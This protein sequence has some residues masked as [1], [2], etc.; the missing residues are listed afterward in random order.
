MLEEAQGQRRLVSFGGGIALSAGSSQ[1]STVG[2]GRGG[3]SPGDAFE[4]SS[5]DEP[6]SNGNTGNGNGVCDRDK[7]ADADQNDCSH[8]DDDDDD[9]FVSPVKKAPSTGR[10]KQV[11]DK[12]KSA[13][14]GKTTVASNREKAGRT[15]DSKSGGPEEPRRSK[16]SGGKLSSGTGPDKRDAAKKRPVRSSLEAF[17]RILDDEEFDL[18]FLPVNAGGGNLPLSRNGG[19]GGGAKGGEALRE[20]GVRGSDSDDECCEILFT[21][22]RPAGNRPA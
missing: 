19:K 1:G 12:S 20:K 10:G 17:E 9:V 11:G 4:L 8:D 15:S 6:V 16:D 14:T 2:V 21:R 5:D 3:C 13:T 18:D 7:D 22:V